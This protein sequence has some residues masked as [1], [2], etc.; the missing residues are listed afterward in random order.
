MVMLAAKDA[1]THSYFSHRFMNT[2]L[3]PAFRYMLSDDEGVI[4]LMSKVRPLV[5]SFQAN[6]SI[7]SFCALLTVALSNYAH[8]SQTASPIRV[9]AFSM[10]K[11]YVIIMQS[12]ELNCCAG[13]QHIGALFDILACYVLAP[14]MG[15]TFAFCVHLRLRGL[16]IGMVSCMTNGSSNFFALRSNRT[17]DCGTM[18]ICCC[19]VVDRLGLGN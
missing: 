16:W 1:R 15:I 13:R 3:H 19:L 10:V 17:V 18:W 2:L 4:S 6:K 14:P 9:E 7:L 5:A 12:I 11:V 8:R